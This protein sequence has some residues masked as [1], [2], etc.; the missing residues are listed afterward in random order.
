[1]NK[2]ISK[3]GL[4]SSTCSPLTAPVNLQA[5]SSWESLPA[6][7]GWISR[8]MMLTSKKKNSWGG[9]CMLRTTYLYMR[10]RQSEHGW[11]VIWRVSVLGVNW[12]NYFIHKWTTN[13][14]FKRSCIPLRM[15]CNHFGDP[16]SYIFNLYSYNHHVWMIAPVNVS[17]VLRYQSRTMPH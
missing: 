13:A 16:L 17:F 4:C 2:L 10:W 11:A 5:A 9:R 6:V 8:W 3:E 7:W 1:M 12:K 14:W 15:N